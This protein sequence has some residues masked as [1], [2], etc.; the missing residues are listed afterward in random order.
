MTTFKQW[1]RNQYDDQELKDIS[2][3][4]CVSGCA[5]GAIYYSETCALYDQYCD[6]IWEMIWNCRDSCGSSN[7]LEF[8]ASLQGAKNVGSDSQF[9]NLLVWFFIEETAIEILVEVQE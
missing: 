3:H 6:E 5:H 9:K 8:I 2:E 1:V 7:C 4:G